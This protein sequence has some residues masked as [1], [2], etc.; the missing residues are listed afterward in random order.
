MLLS[1]IKVEAK[2]EKDIVVTK[3]MVN[4]VYVLNT[5]S[6]NTISRIFHFLKKLYNRE[7][8]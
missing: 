1:L 4:R 6:K 3:L 5:I 2:N 7:G 8:I